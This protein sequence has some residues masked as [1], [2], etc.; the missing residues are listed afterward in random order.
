MNDKEKEE[1]EDG[2]VVPPTGWS[3]CRNSDQNL[4]SSRLCL[5]VIASFLVFKETHIPIILVAQPSNCDSILQNRQVIVGYII[6]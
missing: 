2:Q 1:E 6:F 5:S 4:D 3:L